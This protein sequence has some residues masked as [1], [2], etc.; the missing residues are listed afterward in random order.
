MNRFIFIFISLILI[1][2]CGQ[3]QAVRERTE[4][5]CG[6]LFRTG[7]S[8]F[9]CDSIVSL[10]AELPVCARMDVLLAAVRSDAGA[11]YGDKV[12]MWLAEAERIAPNGRRV[13]VE[14]EKV[15]YN[16][17]KGWPDLDAD[18]REKERTRFCRLEQEYDLTSRQRVWF[19]YNKASLFV[20]TD[21]LN[22]WMWMREAL[23][24]VKKEEN[25]IL[26]ICVLEKF[27]YMASKGGDYDWGVSLWEEAFRIRKQENLFANEW[28]YWAWRLSAHMRR[29]PEALDCCRELMRVAEKSGNERKVLKVLY[30]MV[31]I[32][33]NADSLPRALEVL[34]RLDTCEKKEF[35]RAGVWSQMAEIFEKQGKDDSLKLY[36][37]K[38]VAFWEKNYPNK[39]L[40][41]ALPEYAAYSRILWKEGDKREA[42]DLL[43]KAVAYIPNYA[44][45][46]A[47]SNGGI[48]LL[49]YLNA[50]MQLSEYYRERGESRLAMEML[51]RRDSLRDK[52]V[53][54]DMWYKTMEFTERYRNQELKMRVQ[55]QQQQ[56]KLRKSLL[57]GMLLLCVALACIVLMLWKLYRQKQRRLDDIYR[58]QKE[59]ER[60]ERRAIVVPDSDNQDVLLF[61]RLEK[62]VLE[63]E[64]FRN[65]DLSLDDLCP[66][67]GSNRSYVSACVNRGAGMNFS[68][69]INKIRVDYVLKIIG[70]GGQDLATL[71]TEAGFASLTSFYRNFKLVTRMTPKQYMDRER[72]RIL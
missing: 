13:E 33:R 10:S 41:K 69:W 57:S 4:E 49:S 28:T 45:N 6:L 48:H 59:V 34:R 22:A 50:L 1:A 12:S 5:L 40:G 55:L 15:C 18:G 68:A 47:T 35:F 44:D 67:V 63:Q 21:M 30:K 16:F 23:A 51:F 27:A 32:Y 56:L 52:Y 71:Y 72:K 62:L 14:M 38:A 42:V 24:L 3:K 61:K 26:E 46:G 36:Y 9:Y 19:L 43:R 29:Y 11:N 25:P 58:K 53:E 70:G 7:L 37:R 17:K 54:S 60:L 31:D 8:E 20:N 64:L 66:L 2:G 65:P 39:V